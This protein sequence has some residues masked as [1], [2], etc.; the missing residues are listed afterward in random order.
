M[1][2][3]RDRMGEDSGDSVTD[4]GHCG[5]SAPGRT[6]SLS[7]MALQLPPVT[8][9]AGTRS[10]LFCR[11]P[12]LFPSPSDSCTICNTS[13]LLQWASVPVQ[14]HS[15]PRAAMLWGF[16]LRL[17]SICKHRV[18]SHG[19]TSPNCL[20]ELILV[21]LSAPAQGGPSVTHSSDLSLLIV[22]TPG[23]QG[24]TSSPT[25]TTISIALNSHRQRV[26]AFSHIRCFLLPSSCCDS[27]A[28]SI[29]RGDLKQERSY[30]LVCCP[31]WSIHL[32]LQGHL[33]HFVIS[34]ILKHKEKGNV[35]WQ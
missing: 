9:R 4:G 8:V 26:A 22:T 16:F 21:S 7:Q 10:V 19:I 15:L 3:L 5:G 33:Q 12:Q 32:K 27:F 23:F 35:L 2:S 18:I 30:F 20:V 28:K 13:T 6:T 11:A 14:H 34:G 1:G 29:S 25:A 17:Y 24:R 31:S